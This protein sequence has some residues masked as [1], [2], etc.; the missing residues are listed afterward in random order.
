MLKIFN[1]PGIKLQ[2]CPLI[3]SIINEA[4]D[5]DTFVEPFCGTASVLINL[6]RILKRK[7]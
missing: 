2:Y 3:N 5:V 4:K 6:S 7:L 1:Y